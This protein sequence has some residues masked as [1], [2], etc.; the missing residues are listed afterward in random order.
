MIYDVYCNVAFIWYIWPKST[1]E[2]ENSA[3]DRTE[4]KTRAS[5]RNRM[6]PNNQFIAIIFL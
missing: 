4:D 6:Q 2:K 3:A 5:I 1:A